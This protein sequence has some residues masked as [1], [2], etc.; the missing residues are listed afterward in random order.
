VGH[1]WGETPVDLGER[2]LGGMSHLRVKKERSR[3]G[4]A[5]ADKLHDINLSI[6]FNREQ[7]TCEGEGS[8]RASLSLSDANGRGRG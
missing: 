6:T 8:L 3:L 2:G 4:H 5:G 7:F 1:R